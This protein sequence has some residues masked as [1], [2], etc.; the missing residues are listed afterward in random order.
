[1]WSSPT[2]SQAT[3]STRGRGHGGQR[4]AVRLVGILLTGIA[5]TA[6][7]TA[8]D[9]TTAA[10]DGASASASPEPIP[11]A[12]LDGAPP[13]E[14][15]V[16]SVDAIT[17]H[18]VVLPG[19]LLGRRVS[20]AALGERG[21]VLLS[22]LE[23]RPADVGLRQGRL[24]LAISAAGARTAKLLP[25]GPR[26]PAPQQVS[27]AV[28]TRRHVVWTE[29]PST[30]L[31][32]DPW[33]MYAYDRRDGVTREIT[34]AP[35]LGN[36]HV[37]GPVP[38]FTSAVA[39][40][41]VLT[42]RITSCSPT[43]AV[44]GAA[45]PAITK[46]GVLAVRQDPQIAGGASIVLRPTHGP[47]RV[48]HRL[49]S[50]DVAITGFTA[51][52]DDWALTERRVDAAATTALVSLRGGVE[53]IVGRPGENFGYPVLGI[54]FAGWAETSGVTSPLGAYVHSF[55][56]GGTYEAGN[57]KGLY[58]L[59]ASGRHLAWQEDTTPGAADMEGIRWTTAEVTD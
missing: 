16:E 18:R 53:E 10:A 14:A 38:G 39:R 15:P 30:S 9:G 23:P 20:L 11:S 24:A 49:P 25:L 31:D 33:V 46:R 26:R 56:T 5:L 58:G 36:G 35:R 29:T 45:F 44:R 41:D 3:R 48:V 40:V 50:D 32:E 19:K 52:G 51:S 1:M 4:R 54:G 43:R 8:D 7:T 12:S 22:L 6:C 59:K 28:V 47:L 42:C 21:E 27:G 13:A 57:R 34:R 37:P 17:R 55:A 2:R